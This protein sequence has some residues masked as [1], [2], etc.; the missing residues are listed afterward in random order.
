MR[1]PRDNITT[2]VSS[3][4]RHRS[5]F[6]VSIIPLFLLKHGNINHRGYVRDSKSFSLFIS[7]SRII[8]TFTLSIY[9]FS[10]QSSA[11]FQKSA[12]RFIFLIFEASKVTFFLFTPFELLFTFFI[13]LLVVM[14]PRPPLDPSDFPP[15]LC[16]EVIK[17]CP[18]DLSYNFKV[19][20]ANFKF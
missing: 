19:R 16:K 1:I 9:Y 17:K 10:L 11:F 4:L 6:S 18:F 7:L 2:L 20:P 13:Y 3:F 8:V 15:V 5:L 12:R 14:M